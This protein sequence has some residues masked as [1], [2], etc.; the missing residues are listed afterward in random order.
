MAKH[1]FPKWL[2]VLGWLGFAVLGLLFVA[3][4]GHW[5]LS[6]QA[7][8]LAERVRASAPKPPAPLPKSARTADGASGAAQNEPVATPAAELPLIGGYFS[9]DE[10]KRAAC[11]ARTRELSEFVQCLRDARV[12]GQISFLAVLRALGETVPDGMT[13][14]EAA[15]LFVKK[16]GKFDALLAEWRQALAQRPWDFATFDRVRGQLPMQL[17]MGI[18]QLTGALTEAAWLTGDATA[19]RGH[20]STLMATVEQMSEP[21]GLLTLMVQ[22]RGLNDAAATFQAG[23]AMGAWTDAELASLPDTFAAHNRFTQVA[24]SMEG[25]KRFMAEALDLFRQD[26]IAA[27]GGSPTQGGLQGLLLEVSAALT[28]EQRLQDNL[29]VMHAEIDAFTARFDPAT[30]RHFPGDAS[31]PVFDVRSGSWFERYYYS[32]ANVATPGFAS[33]ENHLV[34]QQTKLDQASIAARLELA[35]RT[36]GQYP[37]ALPTDTPPDPTYGQPYFYERTPEG[38]FRLWGAGH[39]GRNDGGTDAKKDVVWPQ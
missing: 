26:P 6:R 34:D 5:W 3:S 39:D 12:G 31:S 37:D 16:A 27:M 21:T 9:G 22:S 2:R 4:I 28:T 32:F 17:E 19:A 29:A 11:E 24:T 36:T 23:I 10:E 35:K 38:G 8:A 20:W 18:S 14:A 1:R 33:F 7:H 13:E 30:N 25:E 15:A